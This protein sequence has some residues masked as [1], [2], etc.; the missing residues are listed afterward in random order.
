LAVFAA[1]LTGATNDISQLISGL[2]KDSNGV[3]RNVVSN[4]VL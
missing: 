3:P 1:N 2:I 4:I